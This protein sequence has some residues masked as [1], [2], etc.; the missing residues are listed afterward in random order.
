[1]K[2]S[3]GLINVPLHL[4]YLF[5]PLGLKC[6][7]SCLPRSR[8]G[9]IRAAI[10]EP[11]GAQEPPGARWRGRRAPRHRVSSSV[12]SEELVLAVST[13]FCYEFVSET[14]FSGLLCVVYT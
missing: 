14:P 6:L 5:P 12:F 1:M 10:P 4:L 11:P 9:E 3:E 8:L 7:C 13:E 2:L